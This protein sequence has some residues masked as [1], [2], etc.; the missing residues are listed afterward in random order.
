MS[1]VSPTTGHIDS[2]WMHVRT[3][4]IMDFQF[5]SCV[6]TCM[7]L[8]FIHGQPRVVVK[9]NNSF[10]PGWLPLFSH[11][12]AITLWAVSCCTHTLAAHLIGITVYDNKLLSWFCLLC[13]LTGFYMVNSVQHDAASN[14][15]IVQN[16]VIVRRNNQGRPNSNQSI[17][18]IN[19]T[20]FFHDNNRES[21]LFKIISVFTMLIKA[22]CKATF[23]YVIILVMLI[24]ADFLCIDIERNAWWQ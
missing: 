13:W 10:P 12:T 20:I 23:A 18:S 3:A 24:S 5:S 7:L 21:Q 4:L 22:K 6:H 16:H 8:I 1:H 2:Y 14:I 9:N 15:V 19:L 11:L 17:E